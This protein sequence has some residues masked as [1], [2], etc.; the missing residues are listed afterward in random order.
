MVSQWLVWLMLHSYSWSYVFPCHA[1]HSCCFAVFV[2]AMCPRESLHCLLLFCLALLPSAHGLLA[3]TRV[4][5][6]ADV[7]VRLTY[8][9]DLNV[10]CCLCNRKKLKMAKKTQQHSEIKPATTTTAHQRLEICEIFSI[11]F[12]FY[13][14]NLHN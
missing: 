12:I 11:C 6:S 4:A 10:P 8:L 13:Y 14:V 7:A 1:T 5:T 2:C 9:H 3:C